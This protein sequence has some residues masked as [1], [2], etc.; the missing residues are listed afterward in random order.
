MVPF[1]SYLLPLACASKSYKKEAREGHSQKGGR[2]RFTHYRLTSSSTMLFLLFLFDQSS[3][4][5]R[6]VHF[7]DECRHA[8]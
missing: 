5:F 7:V 1:S 3:P 8:R 6:A 4:F 2:A